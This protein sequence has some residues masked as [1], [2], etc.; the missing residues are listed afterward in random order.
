M[1]LD[2]RSRDPE[3]DKLLE[4]GRVIRDVP[5]V[6]RARALARARAALAAPVAPPAPTYATHAPPRWLRIAVTASVAMAVGVAGAAAGL[7]W[8]AAHQRRESAP[9]MPRLVA[10]T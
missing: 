5:D 4:Q 1:S 6:I 9:A 3:L 2:D 7:R 8:R 10:A